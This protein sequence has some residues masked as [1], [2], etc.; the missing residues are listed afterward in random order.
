M[1][2]N[3]GDA[4]FKAFITVT[5]PSGTCTVTGNGQ[6]YTHTG[7]GTTTFTVKKKGTYTVKATDTNASASA[8]VTIEKN[9]ETISKTLKYELLLFN[10]GLVSGIDWTMTKSNDNSAS[11]SI[12]STLKCSLRGGQIALS[13]SSTINLSK[14]NTLYFLVSSASIGDDTQSSYVGARVGIGSSKSSGS[15]NNIGQMS[16]AKKV[17][18]NNSSVSNKTVSLDISSTTSAYVKIAVGTTHV[19]GSMTVTKVWATS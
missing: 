10:S 4:P 11:H 9:G 14:Y 18:S 5:Y 13:T 15:V 8:S 16:S 6:T 3:W 7:G 2:I 1:I 19:A 17:C 12:G